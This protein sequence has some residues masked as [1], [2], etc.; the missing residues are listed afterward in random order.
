MGIRGKI[1]GSHRVDFREC[2]VA[3]RD[4]QGIM[5]SLSGPVDIQCRV[6]AAI[7]TARLECRACLA[8]EAEVAEATPGV[9]LEADMVAADT[10][11]NSSRV[12]DLLKQELASEAAPVFL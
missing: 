6:G 7:V 1:I 11:A 3:S 8:M 12:A 5:G 2:R 10:T 4:T 9:A